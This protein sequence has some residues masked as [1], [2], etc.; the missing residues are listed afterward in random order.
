MIFHNRTEVY[1]VKCTLIITLKFPDFASVRI[2]SLGVFLLLPEHACHLDQMKSVRF[3]IH[4]KAAFRLENKYH[5]VN[6][7]RG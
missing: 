7:S 6:S 4:T 5:N 1:K 2:Q 3:L